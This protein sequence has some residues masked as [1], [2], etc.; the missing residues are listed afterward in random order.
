MNESVWKI[1]MRPRNYLLVFELNVRNGIIDS[2]DKQY[3]T[4][5]L[6]SGYTFANFSQVLHDNE[7]HRLWI[8]MIK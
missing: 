8:R 4:I 5:E 7:E 2:L 6:N 1:A 3:K